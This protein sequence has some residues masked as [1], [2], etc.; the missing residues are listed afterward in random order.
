MRQRF[1]LSRR[2]IGKVHLSG[3]SLR[4]GGCT[5]SDPYFAGACWAQSLYPARALSF[6]GATDAGSVAGSFPRGLVFD[7]PDDRLGARLDVHVAHADAAIA[8]SAMCI[9][10]PYQF[11][12]GA[13]AFYGDV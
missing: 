12:D 7:I 6:R 9:I 13:Q 5:A 10:D 2:A 3:S 4:N 8:M 1:L 11:S